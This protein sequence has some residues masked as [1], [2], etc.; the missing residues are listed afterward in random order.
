MEKISRINCIAVDESLASEEAFLW[1]TENYHRKDDTLLI[2]HIHCMPPMP[3]TTTICMESFPLER[4][5]KAVEASV[6]KSKGILQ[7]FQTLCENK[8]IKHELVLDEDFHFPG[9]MICELCFQFD[10]SVIIIG[11][12]GLQ[13]SSNAFLGSISYYLLHHA[14]IPVIAIPEKGV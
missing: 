1:Y 2:I 12:R 4:Y 5:Y 7:K 8:S 14:Q 3:S 11:T 9:H 6:A 13:K 10:A